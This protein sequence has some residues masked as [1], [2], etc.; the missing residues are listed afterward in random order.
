MSVQMLL[1][2][3]Y[4]PDF[5]KLITFANESDRDF[6]IAKLDEYNDYLMSEK[7]E[8]LS[9]AGMELVLAATV[10]N[11]EIKNLKDVEVIQR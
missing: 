3:E 5:V 9:G 4:D 10:K 8:K 11:Y 7:G 6:F 1:K 2:D